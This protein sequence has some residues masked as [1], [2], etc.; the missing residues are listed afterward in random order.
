V[1]IFKKV[2]VEKKVVGLIIVKMM[3]EI[4][5]KRKKIILVVIFEKVVVEKKVVQLIIVIKIMEKLILLIG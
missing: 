2:V 3:K 1:L 4:F 5:L